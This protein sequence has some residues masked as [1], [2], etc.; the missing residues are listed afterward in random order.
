MDEIILGVD[1]GATKT[2][3]VLFDKNEKKVVWSNTVPTDKTNK[4]NFLKNLF[5]LIE[6]SKKEHKFSSIGVAVAAI[7]DVKT[8]KII[9]SP[10]IVKIIDGLNLASLLQNKFK[11]PVKVQ[12]DADCFSVAESKVGTGKKYENFVGVTL[13]SG[14]GCGIIINGEIYNGKIGES[15]GECGHMIIDSKSKNGSFEDLASGKFIKRV[16]GK[17]GEVLF[18]DAKNGKAGAMKV[19]REFGENL[20]IGLSNIINMMNPEA[21]II[22]G[23]IAEAIK[24][25]LPSIKENIKKYV[26]L[27]KAKNTPIIISKLGNNAPAIGAALL[28]E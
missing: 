2:N 16:Y 4:Q 8:G 21:I 14:I 28:F 11:V 7:V 5:N 3:V 6:L 27:P 17:S 19:C 22:G 9:K 26:M 24:L 12:N 23:G 15:A 18:F 25:I 13:G 10:N 1:I 20:G